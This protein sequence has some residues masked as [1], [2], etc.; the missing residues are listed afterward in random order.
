M[1]AGR[2]AERAQCRCRSRAQAAQLLEDLVRE[3]LKEIDV[4]LRDSECER[5]RLLGPSA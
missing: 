5:L 1:A 4:A 3:G 2:Y